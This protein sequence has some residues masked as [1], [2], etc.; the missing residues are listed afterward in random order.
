M[1]IIIGNYDVEISAKLSFR[2]RSSKQDTLNFLNYLSLIFDDAS[3]FQ[4]VQNGNPYSYACACAKESKQISK[5]LFEFC[6]EQGLYD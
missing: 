1:K 2:A 3:E 6:K 5:D 4:K